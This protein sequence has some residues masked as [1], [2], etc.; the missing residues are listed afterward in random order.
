[1]SETSEDMSKIIE[2]KIKPLIVNSSSDFSMKGEHNPDIGGATQ[3]LVQDGQTNTFKL[4]NIDPKTAKYYT[5]GGGVYG[6]SVKK[7]DN[8][9]EEVVM[10][11]GSSYVITP[12][13][14]FFGGKSRRCRSRK[15]RRSRKTR[16]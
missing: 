5:D 15:N 9:E 16:K 4:Y 11:E 2:G 1:M 14:F 7:D 13:G 8:S 12:K 10:Y 6:I 3:V